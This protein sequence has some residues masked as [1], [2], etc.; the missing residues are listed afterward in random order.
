[1]SE[2]EISETY[3]YCPA[4][5]ANGLL[6]CSG[7]IGVEAD[8]TVPDQPERQ[9]ALAFAALSDVL[10]Q[11][12]CGPADLVDLTSFHVGYPA[13][14]DSFMEAK[15]AFLGGAACCWTAIGAAA[16]GY[17]GSLVEIKAIARLPDGAGA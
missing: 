15:A 9:F 11:H 13:N 7:Q 10:R 2:N 17:P 4:R 1:M 5:I 14:M 3:G 8:G 6:F 16:L 12:R